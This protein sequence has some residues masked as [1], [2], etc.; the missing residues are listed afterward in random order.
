MTK[1]FAK[2]CNFILKERNDTDSELVLEMSDH[3][4]DEGVG[5]LGD[6][7]ADGEHRKEIIVQEIVGSDCDGNY[8]LFGY[9]ISCF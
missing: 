4:I 9:V 3:V 7:G 1:L 2:L 5:A 6:S 8:G